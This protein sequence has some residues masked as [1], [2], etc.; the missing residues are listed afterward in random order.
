M[1]CYRHHCRDALDVTAC[2]GVGHEAIGNTESETATSGVAE[3]ENL[4]LVAPEFF[5]MS[6]D[7]LAVR[8]SSMIPLANTARLTHLNAVSPSSTI[9]GILYFGA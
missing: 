2:R 7:L 6:I 5:G 1:K 9:A 8:M 3:G 4:S